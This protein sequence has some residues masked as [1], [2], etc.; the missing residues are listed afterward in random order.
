VHL[1]AQAVSGRFDIGNLAQYSEALDYF[2]ERLGTQFTRFT[3]TKVQLLTPRLSTTL[4]S[5]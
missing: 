3:S 4:P 2:T 5:V 1:V